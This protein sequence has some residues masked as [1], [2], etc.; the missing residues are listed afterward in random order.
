MLSLFS[1]ITE[2]V[3]G[4]GHCGGFQTLGSGNT[5]VRIAVL[6]PQTVSNSRKFLLHFPLVFLDLLQVKY[7]PASVLNY[8]L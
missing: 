3:C 8:P 6:Q 1:F 2:Q 5:H 4:G 7:N